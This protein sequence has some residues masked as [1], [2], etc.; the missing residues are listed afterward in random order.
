MCDHQYSTRLIFLA[1]EQQ[2]KR[3][4]NNNISN[5]LLET[6]TTPDAC[7]DEHLCEYKDIF[8]AFAEK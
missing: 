1:L 3:W 5:E 7:I 8:I 4:N 2:N 6:S